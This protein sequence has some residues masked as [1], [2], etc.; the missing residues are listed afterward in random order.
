MSGPLYTGELRAL[1]Q[2]H[3]ADLVGFGDIHA[4]GEWPHCVS[5]AVRLPVSTICGIESGPTPDYYEQYHTLNAKLDQLADLAAA[6]IMER[7]FRALAQTSTVVVESAGYRTPFPHK[8][9]ATRSGLGWIGKSALLVTPEFGPAVRLSSVLTDAPFDQFGGPVD[10]SRCG[11]C[12]LCQTHCPGGVIHGA[13]WD[14]SVERER[15]V[16][17]EACRRAARALAWKR[18]EKEITLCGKCIQVCP[19]TQRYVKQAKEDA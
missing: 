9:C 11:G 15:L 5:L 1:L 13:L 17:V 14:V 8:T 6:Y 10:S 7:G 19:Y 4:L 3:G 18:L 12:N 2:S 16:D